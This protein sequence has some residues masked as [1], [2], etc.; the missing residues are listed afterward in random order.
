[1]KNRRQKEKQAHGY[2]AHFC[3][4][5]ALDAFRN[6]N[7]RLARRRE[8]RLHWDKWHGNDESSYVKSMKWSHH[9]AAVSLN[10]VEHSPR[11][12]K[13]RF[14]FG[15]S[16]FSLANWAFTARYLCT[17][18]SVAWLERADYKSLPL[19]EL[20]LDKKKTHQL[21][22]VLQRDPLFCLFTKNITVDTKRFKIC[23]EH[24]RCY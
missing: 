9:F 7:W 20:W 15:F 24:C 18:S 19:R 16:I 4:S 2:L 6:W 23:R 22:H 3:V 10:S 11:Y 1:M 8:M 17:G 14:L 5:E 12:I 21:R 13:K